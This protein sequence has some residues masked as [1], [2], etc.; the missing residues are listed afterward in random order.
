MGQR[1]LILDEALS[2]YEIL[3][4]VILI[5]KL[6]NFQVLFSWQRKFTALIKIAGLA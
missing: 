5:K 3:T 1:Y 6:K 2:R 4:A